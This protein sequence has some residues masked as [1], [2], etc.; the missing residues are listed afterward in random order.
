MVALV[1]IPL[2]FSSSSS[3]SNLTNAIAYPVGTKSK[4]Q[5]IIS[6]FHI[7]DSEIVNR[8]RILSRSRDYKASYGEL[9][10]QPGKQDYLSTTCALILK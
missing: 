4:V 2:S 6:T 1:E 9:Y 7:R 10:T 5:K 3:S 8:I